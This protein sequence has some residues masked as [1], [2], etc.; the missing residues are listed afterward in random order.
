VEGVAAFRVVPIAILV[1]RYTGTTGHGVASA[2]GQ[3]IL[4]H[5]ATNFAGSMSHGL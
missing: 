2:I 3:A 4:T 5:G 1:H